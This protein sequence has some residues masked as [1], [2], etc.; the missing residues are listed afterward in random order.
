MSLI[1]PRA[2]LPILRPAPIFRIGRIFL[3]NGRILQAIGERWRMEDAAH[4][5]APAVPDGQRFG[6][7]LTIYLR[8]PVT[9]EIFSPVSADEAG[10][11]VVP[12]ADHRVVGSLPGRRATLRAGSPA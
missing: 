2:V 6:V 9:R 8:D 12:V 10:A 3:V 5:P 11:A 4:S 1:Q 7:A